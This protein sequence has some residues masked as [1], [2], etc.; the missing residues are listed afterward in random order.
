MA[1][2]SL[3]YLGSPTPNVERSAKNFFTKT[4]I[5][6][7]RRGTTKHRG[8]AAIGYHTSRG[9]TF[10]LVKALIRLGSSILIKLY[11]KLV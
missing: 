6:V 9:T 2:I 7:K 11:D 4:K 1:N 10:F 5:T 3:N 8:E